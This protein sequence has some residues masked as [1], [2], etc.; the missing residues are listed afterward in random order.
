M[1]GFILGLVLGSA[2]TLVLM[3]LMMVSKRADQ[4]IETKKYSDQVRYQRYRKQ[5]E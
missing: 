1:L 2:F 4:V 5:T 3:S